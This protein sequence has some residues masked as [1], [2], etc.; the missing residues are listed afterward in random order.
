MSTVKENST[1]TAKTDAWQRKLLPFIIGSIVIPS[2]L[3]SGCAYKYRDDAGAEHI[4]GLVNMKILPVPDANVHAGKIIDLTTYGI[5]LIRNDEGAVVSIGYN[6]ERKAVI[7]NH[8]LLIGNLF[9][10]E[11]AVPV[12][13]GKE[14]S[15]EDE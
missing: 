12:R 3:L 14:N 4:V 7:K 11:P 6:R 5:T 10:L 8:K 9:D 15:N 1:G 2:V 13:P